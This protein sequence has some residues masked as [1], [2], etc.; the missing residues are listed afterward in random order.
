[1]CHKLRRM[2]RPIECSLFSLLS[3][4][5][6]SREKSNTSKYSGPFSIF[7][8]GFKWFARDFHDS[9][10]VIHWKRSTCHCCLNF[11]S[12]C[13]SLADVDFFFLPF[14]SFE[15]DNRRKKITFKAVNDD[16]PAWHLYI[17]IIIE[18]FA[19][20][21]LSRAHCLNIFQCF[22]FGFFLVC[23]VCCLF[24]HWAFCSRPSK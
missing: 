12:L 1:M 10:G 17:I 23:V 18:V 21:L 11:W 14:I 7:Q 6:V 24:A 4:R 13:C 15:S 9:D 16:A 22:G 19:C 20:Y 5:K 8:N 3:L 2:S